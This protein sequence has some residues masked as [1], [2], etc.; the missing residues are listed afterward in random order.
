MAADTRLTINALKEMAATMLR[1]Y[2]PLA[3]KIGHFKTL[4]VQHFRDED[5]AALKS[6]IIDALEAMLRADQEELRQASRIEDPRLRTRIRN[7]IA[8]IHAQLI[9]IQT[10]ERDVKDYERAPSPELT[11][12]INRLVND[13]GELLRKEDEELTGLEEAV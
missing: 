12:A 7:L 9:R 3:E 8:I 5:V 11:A 13:L 4:V 2:P 1:I 6:V 10:M